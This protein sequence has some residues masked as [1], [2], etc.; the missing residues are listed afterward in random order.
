MASGESA[1]DIDVDR[2]DVFVRLSAD[3]MDELNF[4][5]SGYLGT[6]EWIGSR[7]SLGASRDYDQILFR[8]N[9][10]FSWGNNSL[11]AGIAGG[12]TL[13][14]NAPIEGLL[15]LGGFLRLSGLQED[16]LTGQHAGLATL[17]YTRR[18]KDS[19][20]FRTYVGASIETGNVWQ[21]S[22][23]VAFNNTIFA[24]SL[25]LGM[26]TPIGPLYFAYGH[27]DTDESSLY[28]FIGPRLVF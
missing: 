8:Y 18:L 16:Q 7:E 22:S 17:T 26:A 9:Q 19:S 14:D 23:D 4:P 13:D 2:G 1:Q 12:T 10:A 27:T 11:V 20:L 28:I 15:A 6:T 25:F 21:N 24:G 3:E 5:R